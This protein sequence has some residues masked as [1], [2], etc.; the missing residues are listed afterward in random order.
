MAPPNGA[1]P[2]VVSLSSYPVLA[3]VGA[4]ARVSTN[5]PIALA[6]TA[7]GIIAYTLQCP[8]AGSTV[9]IN[10]N[11]TL[12]CPNHGAEFAFD[13]VWTG[14]TQATISLARLTATPNAAGTEITITN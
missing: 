14:G 13:G 9:N 5:P 6:R 8:H 7:T 10:S 4:A 2:L 3:S 12:R 11:F 1:S